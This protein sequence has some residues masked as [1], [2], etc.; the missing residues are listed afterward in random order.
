MFISIDGKP[1]PPPN[2]RMMTNLNQGLF[3][4][5]HLKPD[6]V[7]SYI[8][9]N[10]S[11]FEP[12][13]ESLMAYADMMLGTS[14]WYRSSSVP[15]RMIPAYPQRSFLSNYLIRA[16]VAQLCGKKLRRIQEEE[17]NRRVPVKVDAFKSQGKDW[18]SV[19]KNYTAMSETPLMAQIRESSARLSP[20]ERRVMNA[21]MDMMI[22]GYVPSLITLD[23]LA[24]AYDIEAHRL[25]MPPIPQPATMKMD[26]NVDHL[27]KKGRFYV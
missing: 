16:A 13:Y 23:S 19:L 7:I 26:F 27:L 9:F 6:S 15:G 8:D 12:T 4:K 21:H 20:N 10:G 24:M 18:K 3:I 5:Q 25:Q 22:Y 2:P 17:L 14:A 1:L 11:D